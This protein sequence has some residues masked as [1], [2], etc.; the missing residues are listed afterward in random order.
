MKRQISSRSGWTSSVQPRTS[1]PTGRTRRRRCADLRRGPL[2]KLFVLR[3][4]TVD[5]G[6]NRV[7]SWNWCKTNHGFNGYK[8]TDSRYVC[9]IKKWKM[10]CDNSICSSFFVFVH[11]YFEKMVI[12]HGLI[13]RCLAVKLLQR[14]DFLASTDFSLVYCDYKTQEKTARFSAK[15]HFLL[16]H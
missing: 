10:R 7:H 6:C 5:L 14:L 13:C 12:D 11:Y 8:T 15:V 1:R 4:W 2:R 9:A 16:P 3:Y